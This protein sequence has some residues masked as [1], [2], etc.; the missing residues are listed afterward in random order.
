M[1]RRY[2]RK[3]ASEPS[4]I[5]CATFED[6]HLKAAATVVR[7]RLRRRFWCGGLCRPTLCL[8]TLTP[9]CGME[10]AGRRDLGHRGGGSALARSQ[11]LPPIRRRCAEVW[12]RTYIRH[13][14]LVAERSM[15]DWRRGCVWQRRR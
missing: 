2:K 1:L 15:G 9:C 11:R 3:S 4:Q 6:G 14:R 8:G 12:R 13:E 5:G 10:L 7:L